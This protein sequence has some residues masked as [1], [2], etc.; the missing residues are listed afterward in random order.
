MADASHPQTLL[1]Y[2]MNNA[3]LPVSFGGPLRLRVPRQLA[4]KSVKFSF[5]R[6]PCCQ[7]RKPSGLAG[8][9]HFEGGKPDRVGFWVTACIELTRGAATAQSVHIVPVFAKVFVPV[10]VGGTRSSPLAASLIVFWATVA[11][12]PLNS[13]AVVANVIRLD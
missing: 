4:Y 6:S 10:K 2:A 9:R 1:T 3:D 12:L 5:Q 13:I 7:G 8:V 11:A